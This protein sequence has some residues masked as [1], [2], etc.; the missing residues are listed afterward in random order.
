MEVYSRARLGQ[1]KP[2]QLDRGSQLEEGVVLPP[3]E[4]RDLYHSQSPWTLETNEQA[5]KR[6]ELG[7]EEKILVGEQLNSPELQPLVCLIEAR[8]QGLLTSARE[9]DELRT[10]TNMRALLSALASGRAEIVR[11]GRRRGWS[12]GIMGEMLDR[13]QSLV[14]KLLQKGGNLIMSSIPYTWREQAARRIRQ[15][16]G[17]ISSI[18]PA[19]TTKD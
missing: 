14:P 19:V 16:E 4:A 12:A 6:P 13:L 18:T 7:V 1:E 9:G 10:G 5:G 3:R 2:H 15:A 17:V 11:M 8:G